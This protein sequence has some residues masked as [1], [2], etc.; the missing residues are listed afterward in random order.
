MSRQPKSQRQKAVVATVPESAVDVRPPA[1][2]SVSQKLLIRLAVLGSIV[3]IIALAA[4]AWWTANPPMF[5]HDQ[6]LKSDA[7][8]I[9]RRID[10]SDDRIKVERV[11]YGA[12]KPDTE[13]KVLNLHDVNGLT[14]E[15]SALLPLSHFRHDYRVT[16]LEGQQV[17]PLIYPATPL[18]IDKVRETLRNARRQTAE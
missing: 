10:A 2:V 18:Y 14:P 13:I 1:P 11:L 3:W 6:V 12:I 9:G 17:D 4:M 15:T 7:V 8:I 5:S 16:L